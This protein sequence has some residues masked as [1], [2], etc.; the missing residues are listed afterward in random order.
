MTVTDTFRRLPDKVRAAFLE[1]SRS[2]LAGYNSVRSP[3]Y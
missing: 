3:F 2:T 1:P